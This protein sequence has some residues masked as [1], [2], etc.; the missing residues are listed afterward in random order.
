MAKKRYR[1][2]SC[3]REQKRNPVAKPS[4]EENLTGLDISRGSRKTHQARL[5]LKEALEPRT[6]MR[7]KPQM[8]WLK[9]IVKDRNGSV[10]LDINHDSADETIAKLESATL[11]DRKKWAAEIKNIMGRKH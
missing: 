6:K 5:A 11:G 7:G 3:T 8:T 9:V 1:A 2:R 4:R 10:E